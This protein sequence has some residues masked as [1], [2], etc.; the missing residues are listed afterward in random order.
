MNCLS[1]YTEHRSFWGLVPINI[2][3]ADHESENM[4]LLIGKVRLVRAFF[5]NGETR[6]TKK[7]DPYGKIFH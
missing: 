3:V 1:A 5:Y 2:E 6:M 4:N 7:N